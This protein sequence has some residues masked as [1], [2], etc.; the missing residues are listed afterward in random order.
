MNN[1]YD[2]IEEII[3]KMREMEQVIVYGAKKRAELVL[4]FCETFVDPAKIQ[5]VVSNLREC[6]GGGSLQ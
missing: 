2:V 6:V 5:V 4:P 3:N 1:Y